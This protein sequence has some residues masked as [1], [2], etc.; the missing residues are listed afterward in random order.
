MT[1]GDGVGKME[2]V[3]AGL[4]RIQVASAL[5]VS[6]SA[7]R[8]MEGRSLHP[9]LVA[10]VWIFDPAE[11]TGHPKAAKPARR[12]RSHSE[13]DI[14]AE[15]FQRLDQGQSLRQIVEDLHQPPD[16]IRAL[17]REWMTPLGDEPA[18]SPANLP[19]DNSDLE[20]WE[21]MMREQIAAEDDLDRQ[22]RELRIGRRQAA[23]SRARQA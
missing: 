1:G 6:V 14:S 7:V 15:V 20:R 16:R 2:G 13:G 8:R 11:I 12:P 23:R 21:T 9:K 17:F 4:T 22:E 3:A 19:D 18:T 5:G 10:G